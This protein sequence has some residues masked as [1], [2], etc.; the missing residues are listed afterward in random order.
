MIDLGIAA[1]ALIVGPAVGIAFLLAVV[2]QAWRT[3]AAEKARARAPRDAWPPIP[4]HYR[5]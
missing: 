1:V 3:D 2:I 5:R 4:R